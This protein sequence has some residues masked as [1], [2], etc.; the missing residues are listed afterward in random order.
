MIESRNKIKIAYF[1][2]SMKPGQDGVTRVLFKLVD[3]LKDKEIDNVFISSLIPA[4]N[5]QMT[6]FLE[7]PSIALPFYKEYKFAY[8]G[9]KK[10]ESTLK[11]FKPDIIHIN[12]PCSLGLAAIKYAERNGIPVV[13]TYHTHFPS[14]AKYYNI[15][16]LEFISWNYL[17]KLYNRCD[18]VLVPSIT[19][20]NELKEQGFKTTEY[21]P[22]GIDLN[23]FNSSYK[24]NEWKKSLNIQD[25]KVLL[26]VGR[27]VWEK[28]LQ[29]LIEVYDHLTGLRDDVSF[30]LV[31]DGP[32]RK[33][34]EKH[35][36]EAQFL[37]YQTGEELSTIYASSDLF[38]FPSTTETFGNVVLEA[39]A[40]G[41]VP[42]CSN[43]GGASSS[44]RNNHNG[45]ICDAKNSFDF[46]KK[47][48]ALINNQTE[49]KRI[50]ENCIDYASSQ[51]WDNI[52]S[53][54]Y[55]HYLEVI[56]QY[57]FKKIAWNTQKAINYLNHTIN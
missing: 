45:I 50:S 23:V 20:M 36:P 32:I 10:F 3:W 40:S 18:L 15:K 7:V 21:L 39:M 55:Q 13:A 9:Y 29:T 12:S 34:L 25:K 28:D 14:Y 51:T 37:G 16:Q 2:G 4:A 54:Q 33:E 22:H 6:K 41:T 1:A 5:E 52:F 30:V 53:M 24:S 46:S 42:V 43:E 38:V 26:F 8:P 17:R 57:S 49:L 35:M 48:L 47:I 56:K 44:I 19:I 27:L 31:G 11:I